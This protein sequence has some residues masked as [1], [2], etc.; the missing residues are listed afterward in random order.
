MLRRAFLAVLALA[1]VVAAAPAGLTLGERA[2]KHVRESHF[3]EGRRSRGKSLFL[4]GTDLRE[5]LKAAEKAK[6]VRQKNGRDK[7]VART[8][9]PVGTDGRTGRPVKTFVV[10]AEPD[11]RVVT[12]YPGR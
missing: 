9:L 8:K 12:M 6:P 10:I 5:L 11:G 7:R 2:E 1:A 4:P 3:A